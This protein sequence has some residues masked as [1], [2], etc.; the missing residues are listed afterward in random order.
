MSRVQNYEFNLQLVQ[1][2]VLKNA[3]I[4]GKNG[5]GKTNLGD[6]VFDLV[7]H[8]TDYGKNTKPYR[9]Y[10]NLYNTEK[11]AC[12]EYTFRFGD[13]IL[14]YSYE[15]ESAEKL[16]REKVTV[17]GKKILSVEEGS[18]PW[19]DL[20]GAESLNLNLWDYSISLVRY[21]AK[22]TILDKKDPAGRVFDQFM[23]FVD[24]MLLFSSA[25]GN[26]YTGYTNG[27]GD[28]CEKII[29]LNAVEEF[30]KFLQDMGILVQL[31]VWDDKQK[32]DI[33]CVFKNRIVP[34]ADIWS[35]GTRALAFLFLW[36]I[37]MKEISFVFIDEFDAFYHYELAEAVVKRLLELDAQ[38]VIT[39]HNTDLMTNDI[40][41]PDCYF[42]LKDNHVKS[43]AD[44]TSKALRQAH[45]IQKMYK[46]GAFDG[47]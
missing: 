8:L 10:I 42:E 34:L 2:G 29:E 1:N 5:S 25:E 44:L 18:A 12:F 15:K 11:T 37:Q 45:N 6:A 30:Q 26:F 41:R 4:Y 47:E 24:H 31:T 17:N 36:Y 28:I 40:M 43:F 22:N 32:K 39:S 13:D 20:K 16:L 35:S 33:Y 9:H 14:I 7:I 19:I 3:I 38:I 27:S 23:D 46:A 21:V